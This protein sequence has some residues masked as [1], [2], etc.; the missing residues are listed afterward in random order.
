MRRLNNAVVLARTYNATTTVGTTESTAVNGMAPTDL[1]V[2]VGTTVTFANTTTKPN[3]HCA[4]Q[5]FEGLFNFN[6][7]PGQSATYTFTQAGEYFYN[8]CFSPRPTGKVE[9]Y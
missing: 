4:T 3:A 7:Q 8:D 2:P 1:R 9:V 5:L 6:L